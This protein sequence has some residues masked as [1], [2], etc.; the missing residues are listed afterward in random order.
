MK[1]LS[2]MNF[3]LCLL[4][5]SLVLAGGMSVGGGNFI[6]PKPPVVQFNPEHAEQV[7]IVSHQTLRKFLQ[8]KEVQLK[9]NQLN[10][11]QAAKFADLFT[12]AKSVHRQLNSAELEIEDDRSC[13]DAVNSPVDGSYTPGRPDQICVSSLNLARKVHPSEMPAQATGL[14]MHEYS[15][16]VGL[17]DDQAVE[18]QKIVL[19][20]MGKV[21]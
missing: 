18:L 11:E 13:F 19:K 1:I 5:S 12:A 6:A 4:S 17:T 7:F 8:N 21:L 2:M 20:E 9:G 14:L 16:S 3:T 10:P 15:E